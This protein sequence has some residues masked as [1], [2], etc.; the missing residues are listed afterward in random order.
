LEI[1]CK[2]KKTSPEKNI[3]TFILVK[4][5]DNGRNL[6]ITAQI[7]HNNIYRNK[8]KSLALTLLETIHMG[9]YIILKLFN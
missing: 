4:T 1:I 5:K 7:T 9:K 6:T 2:E 3:R 8:K